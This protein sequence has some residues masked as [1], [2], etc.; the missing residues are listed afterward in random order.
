[1]LTN[2]LRI[3]VSTAAHVGI[4]LAHSCVTVNRAGP[5]QRV[6][7]VGIRLMGSFNTLHESRKFK[8]ALSGYQ[9]FQVKLTFSIRSLF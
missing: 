5:D 4:Q 2:A 1:M 6:M 9:E 3:L 8:T 7:S